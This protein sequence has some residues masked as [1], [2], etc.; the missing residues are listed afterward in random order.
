MSCMVRRVLFLVTFSVALQQ[1]CP[2]FG[3][4]ASP[5]VPLE[6]VIEGLTEARDDVQV[7][8]DKLSREYQDWRAEVSEFGHTLDSSRVIEQGNEKLDRLESE[9]ET[10]GAELREIRLQEKILELKKKH[11]ED[12]LV[13]I[14]KQQQTQILTLRE[15]V[16]DATKERWFK[17]E[18]ENHGRLFDQIIRKLTEIDLFE[19]YG[20]TS[21]KE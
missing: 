11:L 14:E 9:K 16:Q 12:R 18:I 21:D 15:L 3:Q 13:A 7:K 17:A 19:Q 5:R 2:G 6:S 4:E 8:R 1:S 20:F 10:I